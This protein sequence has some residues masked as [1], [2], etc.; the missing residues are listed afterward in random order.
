MILIS[1]EA[2]IDLIPDP[3]RENAYD[4]VLGGS[5]YNVAIGLGRLGAATAFLSRISTDGNGEALAAGLRD[6]GVDISL[7][8]REPRPTT[9]A[10]VMRGTAKTGSRYSF[11]LDGT[12]YDGPW[13][14][15]AEWPAAARHLHVGSFSAVERHGEAVAGAMKNAGG[16]A[17]VSYDPNIRPF[18]TPDREAVTRLVERQAALAHVV[19]ASEED[20]LW[21][22]P[23]RPVEDGLAAWAGAGPRFCVATLGERGALAMLGAEAIAVPA[24]RVEV[25]DTVGAGD[26][27]MS[28]LLGAMDRDGALG[29]ASAAPDRAA[30]ERWLRFAACASAIT[31]TRK[32]SNPPTRAEVERA[33]AA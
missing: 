15:P 28:A 4:A 33:L 19:K 2:L 14:F 17:T 31:C 12:A 20:L 11:Y 16:R 30:L 25:I 8:V 6:N 9:L 10:F 24:P 1:G 21:L 18:V 22:Y 23:G 7:V 5:P 27:F 32:G 3:E 26:S 13:P 29:A